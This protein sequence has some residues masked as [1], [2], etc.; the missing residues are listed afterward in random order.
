ME[1]V[2]P[3]SGNRN[4]PQL[5]ATTTSAAHRARMTALFM[6]VARSKSIMICSVAHGKCAK[7]A[8]SQT[9]GVLF[10]PDSH[11][12]SRQQPECTASLE[13]IKCRGRKQGSRPRHPLTESFEDETSVLLLCGTNEIFLSVKTKAPAP[14]LLQRTSCPTVFS[15]LL[16]FSKLSGISHED[17]IASA[18]PDHFR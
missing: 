10:T 18:T 15:A 14:S 5:L 2:S 13:F 16:K 1:R 12:Q 11:S 3:T 8:V 17:N 4:A 7:Q 6:F 9:F